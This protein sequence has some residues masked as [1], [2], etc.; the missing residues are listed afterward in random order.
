ML[1]TASKENTMKG[2]T[3]KMAD[4]MV[5]YRIIG[6]DSSGVFTTGP[7]I[8]SYA[9]AVKDLEVSRRLAVAQATGATHTLVEVTCKVLSV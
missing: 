6:R 8:K 3:Q 2:I 7:D 1:T 5:M 9:N 4:K